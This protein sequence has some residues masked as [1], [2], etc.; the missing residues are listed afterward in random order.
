MSTSS[1]TD[2]E[3]SKLYESVNNKDTIIPKK[4]KRI[5]NKHDIPLS[6]R[7]EIADILVNLLHKN[8]IQATLDDIRIT[9]RNSDWFK[10]PGTTTTAITQG[11]EQGQLDQEI[12][13]YA[14]ITD[15]PLAVRKSIVKRYKSYK[16]KR[17]TNSKGKT[18]KRKHKKRKSTI[19]K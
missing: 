8:R 6:D 3:L 15:T 13:D 2:K 17:G 16:S 11:V 9:S 14:K 12:E 7:E 18:K 4:L 10:R 19:K 1:Y 5:L